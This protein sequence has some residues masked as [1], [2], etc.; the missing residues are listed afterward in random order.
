MSL[1]RLA[2]GWRL[3]IQPRDVP[4]LVPGGFSPLPHAEHETSEAD[5]HVE[6]LG[7]V[8]SD[9]GSTPAASTTH[10]LTLVRGLGAASRLRPTSLRAVA[11]GTTPAA[12]ATRLRLRSAESKG[13]IGAL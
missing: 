4:R 5:T 1:S 8:P 13:T 7:E 12:S 3:G 2:V 9:A 11:L 10:S 6:S